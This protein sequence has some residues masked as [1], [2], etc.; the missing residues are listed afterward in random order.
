MAKK[1]SFDNSAFEQFDNSAFEE[2]DNSAFEDLSTE[3]EETVKKKDQ[4]E[5][6]QEETPQMEVQEDTESVSEDGSLVSQDWGGDQKKPVRTA[7]TVEEE[8]FKTLEEKGELEKPEEKEALEVKKDPITLEEVQEGNEEFINRRQAEREIP[9]NLGQDFDYL[10][11]TTEEISDN[12]PAEIDDN[13]AFQFIEQKKNNAL[14][15]LGSD[16]YNK[17]ISDSSKAYLESGEAED[18]EEAK[19]F[20][21]RDYL[22]SMRNLGINSLGLDEEQ[23]VKYKQDIND[24]YKLRQIPSSKRTLEQRAEIHRLKDVIKNLRE[25]SERFFI[26]PETGKIDGEKRKVVK[27]LTAKYSQEA[28]TDFQKFSER[29]KREFDNLNAIDKTLVE[30]YFGD[31]LEE[32]KGE[33][34]L[35]GKISLEDISRMAKADKLPDISQKGK[36]NSL[37]QEKEKSQLNFDALSRALLLNEDPA[38]VAKGF[39]SLEGTAIGDL[40]IIPFTDYTVSDIVKGT[41]ADI[42]A[43]AFGESFA[44]AIPGVGNVKSDRDF[45]KDIVRI[46]NEEGVTLREDQYDSAVATMAEKLGDTFGTSAEIMAEIIA[47]TLITKNASSAINVAGKVGKLVDFFGGG[48][49]AARIAGESLKALEQAVAFDLTSQGSAA[50]GMGE[51]LGAKGADKVLNLLSKGKT[52]KF[53]KFFKPLT[54]VMGAT[55]AGTVEEYG[56]EYLEQ[57]FK[58]GFISKETFRNTFG[59]DYDEAKDKLLMTLILTGTFGTGAEVANMYKLGKDY[60][61]DSGDQTQLNDVEKAYVEIQKAKQEKLLTKFDDMSEEELEKYAEENNVDI[62]NLKKDISAARKAKKL[63]DMSQEEL[64][65]YADENDISI[66]DLEVLTAEKEKIKSDDKKEGESVPSAVEEGQEPGDIQVDETGEEEV[67]T[68]GVLQEEEIEEE[69]EPTAEE[70]TEVALTSETVTDDKGRTFTYF[71]N[72]E[73]K[74]D[75]VKTTYTFNRSDKDSAQ[76]NTTGVKPEIALYNKGYEATEDS[77]P[78]G[79]KI[80]K[81]FEVRVDKNNPN[82]AAADV[83]LINENGETFRGEVVIKPTQQATTGGVLQEEEVADVEP[84]DITAK[85]EEAVETSDKDFSQD[86]DEVAKPTQLTVE[87]AKSLVDDSSVFAV[88][89]RGSKSKNRPGKPGELMINDWDGIGN[90]GGGNV[91]KSI[92][93]S[94]T[95][96]DKLDIVQVVKGKSGDYYI[97]STVGGYYGKAGRREGFTIAV[98]IGKDLNNLYLPNGVLKVFHNNIIKNALNQIGKPDSDGNY[99]IDAFVKNGKAVG[100]AVKKGWDNIVEKYTPKSTTTTDTT[101]EENVVPEA[102]TFTQEEL[103]QEITKDNLQSTIDKIESLQKKI[104]ST[105]KSDLGFSAA[106]DAILTLTKVGLRTAKTFRDAYNGAVDKFKKQDGY[107]KLTDEQKNKLDSFSE[108]EFFDA[109][110]EESKKG[111]ER[112]DTFNKAKESY[113]KSREAGLDIKESIS[114]SFKTIERADWYKSLTKEEQAEIKADYVNRLVPNFESEGKPPKRNRKGKPPVDSSRKIIT[115]EKKSLLAKLKN[116]AKGAK[117][118]MKAQTGLINELFKEISNSSKSLTSNEL[119]AVLKKASKLDP[120]DIT[121]VLEFKDEVKKLIDKGEIRDKKKLAFSNRARINK[122][123]KKLTGKKKAFA[124][125]FSKLNINRVT[126]LDAYNE[127]AQSIIDSANKRKA[128]SLEKTKELGDRVI[129]E[130]NKAQE[131]FNAER[132]RLSDIA[133]EEEFEAF[134]ESMY[135]KSNFKKRGGSLEEYKKFLSSEEG[136]MSLEDYKRIKE[137]AYRESLSN[138]SREKIEQA[139]QQLRDFISNRLEY[140]KSNKESITKD[141][142]PFEKAVV[143]DLI[144]SASLLKRTDLTSSDNL[145]DLSQALDEILTFNSTSGVNKASVALDAIRDSNIAKIKL[146]DKLASGILA[147]YPTAGSLSTYAKAATKNEQAAKEFASLFFGKYNDSFNKS[148]NKT[149][150]FLKRRAEKRNEL[151]IKRK[152]S[153]RIGIVSWLMQHDEG[154]TEEEIQLDLDQKKE[155]IK[156]QIKTLSGSKGNASDRRKAKRMQEAYDSLGLDKV[157]T[158]KELNAILNKNELDFLNFLT[159]EFQEL[160][161]PLQDA[162]SAAKGEDLTF[163]ENYLPTFARKYSDSSKEDLEGLVFDNKSIQS[164]PSGRTKKRTKI[165][166]TGNVIYNFDVLGTTEA[167][168]SQAAGDIYTLYDKQVLSQVVMSKPVKEL[169]KNDPKG[170]RTFKERVALLLKNRNPNYATDAA[171]AN[172]FLQISNNILRTAIALPLRTTDQ[173]GKQV[174]PIIGNTVAKLVLSKGRPVAG[175]KGFSYIGSLMGSDSSPTKQNLK[176]LLSFSNTSLRV[177]EGDRDLAATKGLTEQAQKKILE[178]VRLGKLNEKVLSKLG[179]GAL[180]FADK[181]AS[182]GSW[183]SFYINERIDQ[184]GKGFKFD[185]EKEAE[186][187][188]MKA[189][190]KANVETD[191]IN[192]KSDMTTAAKSV[193]ENKK[194]ALLVKDLFFLF[195]SFAINQS[196]NTALDIRNI[197]Y[198]VSKSFKKKESKEGRQDVRDAA[199]SLLG[200]VAGVYLFEM[201][202]ES[203]IKP[204]TDELVEALFDIEDPDPEKEVLGDIKRDSKQALMK[205]AMD[206]V[207]GAA[208]ESVSRGFKEY[209]NSL[210]IDAAKEDYEELKNEFPSADIEPFSEYKQ[211]VFYD[212]SSAPGFLGRTGDLGAEA[213]RD[214]QII[215]GDEGLGQEDQ[216]GREKELS[217]KMKTIALFNMLA[218]FVGAGDIKKY[219]EKAL[220]NAKKNAKNKK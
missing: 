46:A 16:Y 103:D 25:D 88:T 165:D 29:Y 146:R 53:M 118:L 160:K 33:F 1:Q 172:R 167:G 193:Y 187:P 106:L 168:Y 173:L 65:K 18:I 184:E 102:D 15:K 94:E 78:D 69:V 126:D 216:F 27:D 34:G 111:I 100:E 200:T 55:T 87:E 149:E 51:F 211:K 169:W 136:F 101:T 61:K 185:L 217:P 96:K 144:K 62:S 215:T 19:D 201:V 177:L 123:K 120:A 175:V 85:S 189:I 115:T 80:N 112:G 97:T 163:V 130:T 219:T 147:G 139:E 36:V 164:N 156:Q 64:E 95:G 166:T 213:F 9:L 214:F 59:R 190:E 114:E 54:K 20:T 41:G 141:M 30:A 52:A 105:T 208:P 2:F 26:N 13:A 68:G 133:L 12:L 158:K 67:T 56:G 205:G 49:K 83:E 99:S 110:N 23:L 79:A 196:Y 212:K 128:S 157:K 21:A 28:K 5:L 109:L 203:F 181:L 70:T 202:K 42:F 121:K 86:P 93:L 4:E 186:N 37:L 66:E 125:T 91:I 132:Q 155:S 207:V 82:K 116:Q 204:G 145:F 35:F 107:K 197:G 152:E 122:A 57:G 77:V 40:P 150:Q 98:N 171:R 50:M 199:G 84:S 137:Q 8:D 127:V 48:K 178:A 176:K 24:F 180:G 135:E 43:T 142:T 194:T 195:K 140:L 218:P 14:N 108:K 153:Q 151:K 31:K 60:Y 17:M 209:A 206:I 74:N 131:D 7:L 192:N 45:R 170:Y 73:T 138:Q 104:R 113:N 44:E 47:T 3:Q 63:D 154:S 71:E 11:N 191:W 119:K 89:N 117:T 179:S 182:Q 210:I 198:G 6:P 162:Y 75:I 129:S 188:N 90:Y 72:T 92:D 22:K 183:L 76:R 32:A 124:D 81:V 220:R 39:G 159:E 148:K 143:N 10:S 134:Q 38:A 174:V 58:N 161:Q